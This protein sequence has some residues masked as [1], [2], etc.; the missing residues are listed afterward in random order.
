M[1][2]DF[3]AETIPSPGR[4]NEITTPEMINKIHSIVL[5]VVNIL[6]THLYMRK[7]CVK[8][9]PRLLTTDQKRIRVITSEQ[10]LSYFNRNP[11]EFLRPFV[12]MDE[13][14]IRRYTPESREGSKQW[15]K[16]GESALKRPKTQH[17]TRKVIASVFWDAHGVIYIDYL[18]KGRIITG[19]Y[20]AVLLNRLV[21]EIRKK[22]PHMKKQKNPFSC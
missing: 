3:R 22:R 17:S 15:V 20:Y 18:E 19:A 8:W 1:K 13:T 9:M 7:L 11:K 10:N 4:P 2:L 14:W 16:P 6:H 21:V 5:N 12:T